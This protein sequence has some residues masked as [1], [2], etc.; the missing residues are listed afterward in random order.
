M[1]MRMRFPVFHGKPIGRH[2]LPPHRTR[3]RA[4]IGG[5]CHVSRRST[6]TSTPHGVWES[7]GWLLLSSPRSLYI[8]SECHGAMAANLHHHLIDNASIS[9][10][11]L[12]ISTAERDYRLQ[13]SSPWLNTP[14]TERRLIRSRKISRGSTTSKSAPTSMPISALLQKRRTSMRTSPRTRRRR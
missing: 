2:S 11:H 14:T 3:L 9:S 1:P 4:C 7:P 8:W 10:Q 6:P 12:V 13:S 5:F